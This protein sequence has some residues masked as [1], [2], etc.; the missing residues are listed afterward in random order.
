MKKILLL[1][2]FFVAGCQQGNMTPAQR[3]Q[4]NRN[5]ADM[6]KGMSDSYERQLDRQYYGQPRIIP[7]SPQWPT[8]YRDAFGNY[9][10]R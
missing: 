7:L 9:R 1:L 8:Y 3:S 4:W 10:P 2:V 6:F 5:M